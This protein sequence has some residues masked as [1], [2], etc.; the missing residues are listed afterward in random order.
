MVTMQPGL[1]FFDALSGFFGVVRHVMDFLCEVSGPFCFCKLNL[2]FHQFFC[3]ITA[4]LLGVCRDIGVVSCFM[5]GAASIFDYGEEGGS[6]QFE[7]VF[8]GIG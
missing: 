1:Y 7:P 3:I 8:V 5:E 4:F 6:A 2:V